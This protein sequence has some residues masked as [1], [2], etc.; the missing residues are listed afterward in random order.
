MELSL[1]H[2]QTLREEGDL[3]VVM[4]HFPPFNYKFESNEMIELFEKYCVDKVV[5]GHLHSYDKNQKMI[6]KRN[7]I[8][9]MLTS[10]DLVDN[11]LVEVL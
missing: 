11:K 6:F 2:M 10:C 3:V 9:Y 7:G 8:E 5:F 1:R 4:T